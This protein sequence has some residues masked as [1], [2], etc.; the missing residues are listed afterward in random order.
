MRACVR[1][2]EIQR[3]GERRTNERTRC[4]RHSRWFFRH[5][6]RERVSVASVPP[7][8][9]SI[10]SFACLT[11]KDRGRLLN[12]LPTL[13]FSILRWPSQCSNSLFQHERR[14]IVITTKC[15]FKVLRNP[16]ELDH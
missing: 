12:P 9:D 10:Q 1:A 14:W 13:R 8:S 7:S 4:Y 16:R 2:T 11:K 3:E 5:L 15:P 6:V